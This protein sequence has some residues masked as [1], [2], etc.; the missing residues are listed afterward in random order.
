MSK[1]QI[2][3]NGKKWFKREYRK[4]RVKDKKQRKKRD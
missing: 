3:R 4:K 2:N 1:G